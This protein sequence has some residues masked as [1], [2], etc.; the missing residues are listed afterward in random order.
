[1]G[2]WSEFDPVTQ[3]TNTYHVDDETG[4]IT[5]HKSQ[6]VTAVIEA[7]KEARRV[8]HFDEGKRPDNIRKYCSIPIGIQYELMWKHGVDIRNR[9]HWPRMFHLINTEYT[10]CK[11]TDLTHEFKNGSR[12]V[13]VG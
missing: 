13:I 8:R 6:D 1:M 2:T 10:D 5:V 11:V 3:V 7:N 4:A 9:D 12:K